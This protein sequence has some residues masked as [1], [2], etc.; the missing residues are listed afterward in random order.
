MAKK[1]I[2]GTRR[3]TR[4][5]KAPSRLIEGSNREMRVIIDIFT[6]TAAKR[7]GVDDA[8]QVK[9]FGNPKI[10]RKAKRPR[11]CRNPQ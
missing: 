2:E 7:A 8:P 9:E 10:S 6:E 5:S 3:S 11:L 1:K 4:V